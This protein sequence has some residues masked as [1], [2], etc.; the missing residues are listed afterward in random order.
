MDYFIW[1][2]PGVGSLLAGINFIVTILKM[3]CPGMTLMKMPIFVWA[4]FAAMI[5]VALAFP[6]LTVTLGL[7][8]LDRTMHMNFFTEDLGGIL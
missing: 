5:L 6:I 1:A 2:L 8:A 7:L 3:R 4:S